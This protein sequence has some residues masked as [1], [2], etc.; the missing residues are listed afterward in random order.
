[1]ARKE[2]LNSDKSTGEGMWFVLS[3]SRWMASLTV[4]S[5]GHWIGHEIPMSVGRTLEIKEGR[6]S[7]E[8]QKEFLQAV[9]CML[10]WS[11]KDR[12]I[13]EQLLDHP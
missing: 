3:F 12:V 11:L 2:P 1:M 7:V 8:E 6:S 10:Q 13:A 5:L 4:S 9:K